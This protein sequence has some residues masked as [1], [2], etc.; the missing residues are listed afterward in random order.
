MGIDFFVVYSDKTIQVVD[1]ESSNT[2]IK[3]DAHSGPV[4]AIAIDPLKSFIVSSGCD[5]HVCIWS[6]SDP[7]RLIKKWTNVFPT[8]NDI[9]TSSTLCRMAWNPI[10]GKQVAIPVQEK[11]IIYKRETWEEITSLTCSKLTKV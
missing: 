5:G 2:P 9:T 6:F 1:M 4:L 8:S 10:G 11:I 7:K 3:I